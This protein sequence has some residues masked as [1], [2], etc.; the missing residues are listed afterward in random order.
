MFPVA[1]VT[2]LG[3]YREVSVSV[4]REILSPSTP[5]RVSKVPECKPRLSLSHHQ[6]GHTSAQAAN[7]RASFSQCYKRPQRNLSSGAEV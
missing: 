7:G 3:G 5:L 4:Q 6:H 2:G 1:A